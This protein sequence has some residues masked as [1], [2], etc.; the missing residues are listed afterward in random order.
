MTTAPASVATWIR[1]ALVALGVEAVDGVRDTGQRVGGTRA[2][3]A[4]VCSHAVRSRPGVVGPRT[5]KHGTG[6][7]RPGTGRFMNYIEG[8]SFR[9]LSDS[10][11]PSALDDLPHGG[12]RR[13]R[14]VGEA[15]PG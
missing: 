8:S 7:S 14:P 3:P 4:V 11:D 1:I 9:G 6:P 15:E 2:G 10:P 13:E 12:A 5:R